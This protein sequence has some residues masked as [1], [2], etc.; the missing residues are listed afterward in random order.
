MGF[1]SIAVKTPWRAKPTPTAGLD[2]DLLAPAW[3]E[4]VRCAL[5]MGPDI[6]YV[7]TGSAGTP[8]RMISDEELAQRKKEN[9]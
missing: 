4:G 9:D 1:K 3:L 8:R 2:E 6:I 7:I 5:K